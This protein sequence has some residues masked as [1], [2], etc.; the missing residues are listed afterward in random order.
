M[1]VTLYIH[2][3]NEDPVLVEMDELPKPT[4]TLIIGRHPRYRDNKEV[5]FLL[6]E[7]TTV[8]FP[9]TRITFIEVMPS[10]DEADIVMPYRTDR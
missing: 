7:V 2:L 9:M 4:D 5:R 6:P 10:G 8:I 1:P 3:N